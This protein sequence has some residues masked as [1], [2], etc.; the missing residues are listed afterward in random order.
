MT[1]ARH[2]WTGFTYQAGREKIREYAAATGETAAVCVDLEAAQAAGHRDLVAPPMFVAVYAAPAV[3]VAYA[4]PMLGIDRS[5]LVHGSQ[6]FEWGPLVIA[7]DQL[8]TDVVLVAIE[9]KAPH[10]VYRFDSTSTNQDG[11]VVAVGH[12][13]NIVRGN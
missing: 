11:D 4:D 1:D 2:S 6:E 3:R 7:G 10:V 5:R 13:L 8:T 12:W 9:D